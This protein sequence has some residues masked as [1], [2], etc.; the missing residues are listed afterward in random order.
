MN[1]LINQNQVQDTY[2]VGKIIPRSDLRVVITREKR[3]V[4]GDKQDTRIATWNAR[5]LLQYGKLDNIKIEMARVD[6][7]IL[8]VSKV[9]WP[10]AGDI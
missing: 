6:I 7:D 2:S 1:P 9:R 4:K 10:E 5:T 8:G 3:M